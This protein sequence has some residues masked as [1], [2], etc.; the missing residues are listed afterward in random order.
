VTTRSAQ[1]FTSCADPG[2]ACEGSDPGD[3]L[4][5]AGLDAGGADLQALGVPATGGDAH[6]LDVRVPPAGCTPVGAGHVV[7]EARSLATDVAHASH[8]YLLGFVTL[9]RAHAGP[10]NP[11]RVADRRARGEI[12]GCRRRAVAAL[13]RGQH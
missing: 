10:G 2:D 12:R 1:L 9:P 8:G 5:L 3:A 4:D 7:A 6:G 13:R 11:P